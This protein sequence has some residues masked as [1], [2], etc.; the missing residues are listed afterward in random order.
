MISM[1]KK[2]KQNNASTV[3]QE[4]SSADDNNATEEIWDDEDDTVTTNSSHSSN[5][6]VLPSKASWAILKEDRDTDS[7]PTTIISEYPGLDGS[8]KETTTA[9]AKKTSESRGGKHDNKANHPSNKQNVDQD[10]NNRKPIEISAENTKSKGK[11]IK[12]N[13]YSNSNLR[14]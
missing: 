5:N 1:Q 8:S 2:Q 6:N 3:D 13:Y 11:I 7:P 12:E 9:R 14:R 10:N 4:V